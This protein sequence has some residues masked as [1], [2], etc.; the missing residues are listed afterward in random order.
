M[1]FFC[2][3]SKTCFLKQVK[4]GHELL[5]CDQHGHIIAKHGLDKRVIRPDIVYKCLI[6]LFS[7][8]LNCANLL[9]VTLSFLYAFI[10]MLIIFLV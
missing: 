8:P 3:N 2:V 9:Q 10:K 1:T 7:S 6:T 5:N 4:K